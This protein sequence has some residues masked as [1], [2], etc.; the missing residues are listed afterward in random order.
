[1]V[2]SVIQ[3]VST[4]L[5]GQCK[6][7]WQFFLCQGVAVGLASGCIFG[8]TLAVVSHWCTFPNSSPAQVYLLIFSLRQSRNDGRQPMASWQLVHPLE[9]QS[10]L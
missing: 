8:P 3:V 2:A 10:I 5:V 7:Y 4:L 9:A 1:M 6:E